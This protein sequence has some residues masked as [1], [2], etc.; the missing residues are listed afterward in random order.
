MGAREVAC[1]STLDSECSGPDSRASWSVMQRARFR[2]QCPAR[3]AP[4]AAQRRSCARGAATPAAAAATRA[5]ARR[6]TSA[7]CGWCG[8]C[9]GTSP[10]LPAGRRA[11][12]RAAARGAGCPFCLVRRRCAQLGSSTAAPELGRPGRALPA[13]PRCR[14]YEHTPSGTVRDTHPVLDYY[15]GAVFMDRGGYKQLVDNLKAHPPTPDEVCGL[16]CGA[17]AAPSSARGGHART[18]TRG[19]PP[20][21][22]AFIRTHP[23][24]A[25]HR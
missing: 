15:T 25:R 21:P 13:H 24:G 5:A 23:R 9:C 11:L 4:A 14:R 18:G 3:G 2:A 17:A 22:G 7:S 19:W 20:R 1:G 10:S 16:S 8:T 6:P 12:T